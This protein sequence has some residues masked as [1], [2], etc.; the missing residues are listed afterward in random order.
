M[1]I[2]WPPQQARGSTGVSLGQEASTLTEH[3]GLCEQ[4]DGGT[5]VW[6]DAAEISTT[7]EIRS[8][9]NKSGRFFPLL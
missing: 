4:E 6:S 1:C 5:W 2:L 9:Q 3:F 8:V 7:G